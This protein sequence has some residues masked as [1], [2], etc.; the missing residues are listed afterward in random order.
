MA[1][2]P[3]W[4]EPECISLRAFHRPNTFIGLWWNFVKEISKKYRVL[5]EKLRVTHLIKKFATFYGTWRFNTVFI[6]ARHWSL[7]YPGECNPHPH[8]LFLRHILIL[9]SHL[10]LGLPND[11]FSSVFSTKILY[12]TPR[13]HPDFIT[14]ITF[15]E[16]QLQIMT[17]SLYSFLHSPVASLLPGKYSP[18][19]SVMKHFQSTFSLGMRGRARKWEKILHPCK[20]TG[21]IIVLYILRF[22]LLGDGSRHFRNAICSSVSSWI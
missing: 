9:S 18:Q 13:T 17:S 12:P 4:P 15:G 21:K 16:E 1:I 7:S 20:A 14:P 22:R 8:I 5:P 6:R 19:N 11:L 2:Q 10:L 3:T